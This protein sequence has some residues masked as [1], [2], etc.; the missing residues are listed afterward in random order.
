MRRWNLLIMPLCEA[1]LILVVGVAAW[2]SGQPLLFASLGPTAYELVEAPERI[3]ARPYNIIIGHL[4]G[5]LSGFF[6]LYVTHRFAAGS[7]VAGPF[8][9][10][11]VLGAAL[12]AL[13]TV[14]GTLLLRAT[15]PAAVS[16][17]LL[18]E[19]GSMAHLRDGVHIMI[20]ILLIT[21]IGEPLRWLREKTADAE[22]GSPHIE[23][24]GTA[25]RH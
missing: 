22:E 8:T 12:A 2:L 17:S 21:A 7:A 6:A 11:R 19:L 20:A 18:V 14:F 3:T 13:L 15:Q 25:E 9:L 23:S 4:I 10:P 16:T 5:V 1:A 24:A